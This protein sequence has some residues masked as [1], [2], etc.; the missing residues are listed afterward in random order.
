MGDKK[1]LSNNSSNGGKK[2]VGAPRPSKPSMGI[3]GSLD[4]NLTCLY[5]KY[6]GYE[7]ENC[8][9]LQQKLACECAAMWSIAIEESIN[10]KHHSR[11]TC[12]MV[13]R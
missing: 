10:T 6:T 8:K 13:K 9:Q 7:L 1:T 12:L 11:R 4:V 2:F 3:D 5:C